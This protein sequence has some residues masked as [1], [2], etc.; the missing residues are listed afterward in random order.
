MACSSGNQKTATQPERKDNIIHLSAAIE[1]AR[2]EMLLSEL[3]D[4]ISYI[5]METTPNG[6]VQVIKR[7]CFNLSPE[8]IFYCNQCYDWKGKFIRSIGRVGQGP[9]EDVAAIYA[10]IIY[11]KGFFYGNGYKII[12]YDRNGNCTGK[13]RTWNTAES[14]EE[15]GTG[16]SHMVCL[17][18]AGDNLMFYNFLDTMYFMDT[19][20]KFVAKR[21]MMPSPEP[22]LVNNAQ[23]EA[24]GKLTTFYKDTVLFY[25]FYTDT[26][27][28]VNSTTLSP[29]WVVELKDELRIAKETVYIEYGAL[30][31]EAFQAYKNGTTESAEILKIMD[32]KYVVPVVYETD[33]F[34]FLDV[35]MRR[36]WA[37]LRNLPFTPPVLAVYNKKTGETFGVNKIIDDLG[38]MKTFWPRLGI[39]N[40]KM[41]DAIWPYKLQEFINEEKEKGNTVSPLL[42]DLMKRVHED[43]NPILIIAH[44]KTK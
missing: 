28:T 12:E 40:N 39:C 24:H 29:R 20:Y 44:L 38:G 1:N 16:F 30:C 8:H 6:M 11:H 41:V 26:I 3:V 33:D 4:S 43:D 21:A 42:L 35:Y 23:I 22:G 9:C 32:G 5:P 19:D 10:N 7:M 25:N 27:F 31:A 34:V 13:E 37:E 17:A 36:M 14:L 18:P 15:Q 2:E